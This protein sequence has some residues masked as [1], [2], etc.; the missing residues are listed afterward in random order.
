VQHNARSVASAIASRARTPDF[1]QTFALNAQATSWVKAEAEAQGVTLT[2]SQIDSK[3]SVIM[4]L[5]VESVSGLT[6]YP[7]GETSDV[8]AKGRE[9]EIAFNPSTYWTVAANAT[10]QESMDSNMGP[11]LGRYIAERL[12][13]WEKIID[14]TNGEPWY[15]Y[16]YGGARSAKEYVEAVAGVT[17]PYK[18]FKATEGKTRAQIR[19]YNFRLST[20]YSWAGITDNRVIRRN[21]TGTAERWEDKA[22]IGYFC[23]EKF[24]ATITEL[25]INNPIYDR[26]HLY[27][28]PWIRYSVRL[29]GGKVGATFQLNIKNVQEGGRLQ[30]VAARPDG[31][32]LAF[33]IVEPRQFIFTASFDL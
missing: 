3:I 29:F 8:S 20:R 9:V 28:D 14:P 10:E 5:P 32:P 30:P 18:I 23:V 6:V 2:Q 26:A 21:T 7:V 27:V 4:G 22:A 25:D 19:K 1:G 11:A 24:P 33:R 15:S 17:F 16:P 31:T 12:A 13:V